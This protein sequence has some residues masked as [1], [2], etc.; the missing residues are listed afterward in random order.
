MT[1]VWHWKKAIPLTAHDRLISAS[2]SCF[3]AFLDGLIDW[4]TSFLDIWLR[5]PHLEGEEAR[6]AGVE[7]LDRT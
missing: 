2:G 5:I 7:W 1:R 6:T 3:W 4:L